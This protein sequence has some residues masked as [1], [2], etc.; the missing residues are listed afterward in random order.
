LQWPLFVGSRRHIAKGLGN[1]GS[2][3][4]WWCEPSREGYDTHVCYVLSTGHPYST[5]TA[6]ATIGAPL[7]FLLAKNA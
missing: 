1:G 3:N 2:K 5:A 4:A 7:C 6:T